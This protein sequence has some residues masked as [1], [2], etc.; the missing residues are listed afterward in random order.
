[1]KKNQTNNFNKTFSALTPRFSPTKRSNVPCYQQIPA[2]KSLSIESQQ[3]QCNP[4]KG[5]TNQE[6][7]S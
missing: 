4:L 5:K 6:S 3:N 7:E 2:D 1:M